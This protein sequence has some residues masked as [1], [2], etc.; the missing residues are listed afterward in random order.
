M[1][2]ARH[3]VEA[4]EMKKTSEVLEDFGGPVVHSKSASYRILYFDFSK[5]LSLNCMLICSPV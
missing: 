1:A 2:F 5:S 4:S 3:L